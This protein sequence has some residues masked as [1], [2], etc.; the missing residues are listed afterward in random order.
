M[1]EIRFFH[2]APEKLI[3]AC[4]I[5]AAAF[6]QGRKV[7]VLASNPSLAYRFDTLLWTFQALAFIPHV[8]ADS[9]LASETPVLIASRLD[10][11]AP[12]DVLINLDDAV[13]EGFERFAQ[14]I[15]IVAQDLADREQAR[16]RWGAYKKL[17][18]SIE[19]NDLGQRAPP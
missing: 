17:G 12:A 2:N 11:T 5:T 10:A 4:R 15:E 19:G 9:V 7:T 18:L 3:A 14:L 8:A 1:T 13:P 16:M 6:R